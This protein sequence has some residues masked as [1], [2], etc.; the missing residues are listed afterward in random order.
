MAKK[1][2]SVNDL[3][4]AQ[5]MADSNSDDSIAAFTQVPTTDNRGWVHAR[6][7]L[8]NAGAIGINVDGS[9]TPVNF[10]LSVAANEIFI[11]EELEIVFTDKG[12]IN[13]LEDFMSLPALTN[14]I[15]ISATLANPQPTINIKTNYDIVNRLRRRVD[16]QDVGTQSIAVGEVIFRA[17]VVVDGSLGH[18]ITATIQDNLSS[19]LLSTISAIGVVKEI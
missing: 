8:N 11:I 16:L 17:P 2:Y 6:K 4:Y 12:N 10:S 15:L 3:S 1:N 9:V 5:F 14:G 13:S 19:L 18:Q 7:F